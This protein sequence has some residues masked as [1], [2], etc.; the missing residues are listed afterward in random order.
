MLCTKCKKREAIYSPDYMEGNFCYSCFMSFFE[1]QVSK[2]LRDQGMFSEQKKK[3]TLI[4]ISN[5]SSLVLRELLKKNLD[6]RRITYASEKLLE[7]ET[8]N[9]KINADKNK[10]YILP[11]SSEEIS[12]LIINSFL[13]NKKLSL[14]NLILPFKKTKL[15]EIK[16]Y[17]KLKK[18]KTNENQIKTRKYLGIAKYKIE[19]ISELLKK[20]PDIAFSTIA[21]YKIFEK[22]T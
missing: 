18:Y 3:L 14:K 2:S 15:E 6:E 13:E 1:K 20:Y 11:L 8:I 17:M 5:N 21:F 10:T 12:M 22:N 16:L 7:E 4:E 19:K 9:T